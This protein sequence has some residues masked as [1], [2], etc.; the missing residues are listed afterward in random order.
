[1][2]CMY[3]KCMAFRGEFCAGLGSMCLLAVCCWFWSF[4]D[5]VCTMLV[6]MP[7]RSYF[8]RNVLSAFCRSYMWLGSSLYAQR[9]I[10]CSYSALSF[11]LWHWI[12]LL[13]FPNHVWHFHHL[14]S[15]HPV[16][17]KILLTVIIEGSLQEQSSC[18][19][20]LDY[21]LL[22]TSYV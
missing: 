13:C 5:W 8:G 12:F 9:T 4:S 1:M 17:S 14:I 7:V 18:W 21:I 15:F 10:S 6:T 22:S 16:L 3:M 20:T 19:N 11:F 2:F